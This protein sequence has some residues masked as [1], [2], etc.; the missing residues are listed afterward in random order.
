MLKLNNISFSYDGQNEPY[1]FNLEVKPKEIA[2][3][4]GVSGAGKSTLLDLIAGFLKPKNGSIE[5][6]GWDIAGISTQ[7][8][9]VSILLQSNNLFEHLSVRANLALAFSARISATQ[10][11]EKISQSLAEVDLE[12][13]EKRKAS[14]LSG[15][16]KQR[17]ALART[18]LLDREILLLDEPF[19]ALDEKAAK[20]MQELLK[21]LVA[22]FNWHAIVVSHDKN[23]V[24]NLDAVHYVLKKHSL[25]KQ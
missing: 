6:N 23:D 8:R 24:L 16:Q 21:K 2:L 1:I 20:A 13:F 18:L 11:N 12:G 3:I 17:I 4:S 25:I 5:L 19:A 10:I 14:S 7:K 9:P 15:G 22:K